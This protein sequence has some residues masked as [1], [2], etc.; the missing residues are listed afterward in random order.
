M[1]R[2]VVSF[3]NT[4]EDRELYRE[5]TSA[6]DKSAYVKDIMKAYKKLIYQGNDSATVFK[7]N[8]INSNDTSEK[9]DTEMTGQDYDNTFNVVEIEDIA[10]EE[11]VDAEIL[12][13]DEV[14][15]ESEEEVKVEVEPIKEISSKSQI[16]TKIKR[17]LNSHPY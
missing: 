17:R 1:P 4:E 11:S 14:V 6:S 15:G 12:V 5:I 9:V 3:K 16:P 8:V 2:V 10:N 7:T 13:E